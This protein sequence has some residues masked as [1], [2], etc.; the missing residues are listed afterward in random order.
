MRKR[1][2]KVSSSFWNTSALPL[3][4]CLAPLS[5]AANLEVRVTTLEARLDMMQLKLELFSDQDIKPQ[6]IRTKEELVR[7]L[8]IDETGTAK[9]KDPLANF[10]EV[11]TFAAWSNGRRSLVNGLGV[12]LFH[13]R[14]QP[15]RHKWMFKLLLG[16]EWAGFS[17]GYILVSV[18]NFNIGPFI[19]LDLE[20]GPLTQHK[21]TVW[22]IQASVFSF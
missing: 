16:D 18:I 5:N 15:R 20:E 10:P 8:E 13:D 1:S 2:S 22:G 3:L 6:G 14:N 7:D 17:A 19:G 12:E 21:E 9:R 11:S 4:L